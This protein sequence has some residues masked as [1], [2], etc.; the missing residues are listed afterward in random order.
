MM[1]KDGFKSDNELKSWLDQAG[2]FCQNFAGQINIHNCY[3]LRTTTDHRL[4][5]IDQLPK[6]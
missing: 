4:L 3:C 5:T 2:K 1:E 6:R